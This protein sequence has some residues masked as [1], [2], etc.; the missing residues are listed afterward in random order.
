MMTNTKDTCSL[1]FVNSVTLQT[2][3]PK[4][5]KWH[6][7]ESC[8]LLKNS[9]TMVTATLMIVL[10]NLLTCL[11]HVWA[12]AKNT[13]QEG[14]KNI[15]TE[16]QNWSLPFLDLLTK[17][18]QPG[19]VYKKCQND[20]VTKNIDADCCFKKETPQNRWVNSFQSGSHSFQYNTT[21][22]N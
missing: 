20:H 4:Y 16:D 12:P 11:K 3:N 2:Q 17:K 15:E 9:V 19:V 5:W 8:S 22:C 1:S 7:F 10:N 6:V 18:R 13:P 21:T 14:L